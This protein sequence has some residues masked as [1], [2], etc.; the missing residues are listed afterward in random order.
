VSGDPAAEGL[1]DSVFGMT[2]APSIRIDRDTPPPRDRRGVRRAR[3][4]RQPPRRRRRRPSATVLAAGVLGALPVL[5]TLG[6]VPGRRPTLLIE[7]MFRGFTTCALADGALTPVTMVCNRAGVPLGMH[8]LDGGLTYPLG[9]LLVRAGVDALAAWK[10]AVA[11]PII[12]GFAALFWLGRRLAGSTWAAAGLVT[13][14]ALNGTLASRSWNWYW[15]T[16]AVVMLPAL[17]AA[18][19]VLIV[20]AQRVRHD[21]RPMLLLAGPALVCAALVLLI[22]IEWQYAA[23]FAAAIV[24][25]AITLLLFERGWTTAQRLTM[26]TW[27]VVAIT[28]CAGV[29]RWRMVLAGVDDQFN[30]S[31]TNAAHEGIDLA[32]LVLPDGH[33]SFLGAAL[34]LTGLHGIVADAVSGGRMLWI[35]PY[36]GVGTLVVI[37]MLI[38]RDR[39]RLADETRRPRTFLI[40]LV[41]MAVGS[42]LLSLGPEWQVANVAL[43]DVH[44]GSPLPWLWT[45]TPLRWIRY[46]WTWNAVTFLT[47]AL[48]LC[49]I[50]PTLVGGG[51]RSQRAWI[52]GALIVGELVSPQVLATIVQPAPSVSNASSRLTTADPVIARF[53]DEAVPELRRALM[54]AGGMVTL[55]PWGNTW[56]IPYLGP[57]AG[58]PMRNVGIDRNVSQVEAAAPRTRSQIRSQVGVIVD[59]L[60]RERWT[61]T[62]V[63]VDY[64][65]TAEHIERHASGGLL[66]ADVEQ[67]DRN[68][69]TVREAQR[70][71]YCAERHSWFT[72]L[73][74]CAGRAD[75]PPDDG[76]T[77]GLPPR[78]VAPADRPPD[79]GLTERLPPR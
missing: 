63:V 31:L 54:D 51:G 30:G 18:L 34:R 37:G 38:A 58:V 28:A 22:G 44:S 79:N 15:N 7:W 8:Q 74:D 29:L 27:A 50:V 59:A 12:A 49:A 60:F 43:P 21:R 70:L 40:L 56:V 11:V 66:V 19:H 76:L 68:A 9:G 41:V 32:A 1:I 53:D 67:L 45:S 13:V 2:D 55:L 39:P 14:V 57:V 6:A 65:P 42:L 46:P 5:A 23:V 24:L 47:I 72:V 64:I 75:R 78:W 10:L 71:G 52:V 35:A 16:V 25:T 61:D 48:A 62:I 36:V 20:R 3:S 33:A 69:Q 73:T 26:L 17:F 4:R 77:D